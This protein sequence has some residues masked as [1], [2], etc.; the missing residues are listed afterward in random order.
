[1]TTTSIIDRA[2]SLLAGI[3]PGEWEDQGRLAAHPKGTVGT[4]ETRVAIC[5]TFHVLDPKR[6]I[7]FKEMQANAAFIAAS[8]ELV[9]GLVEEVKRLRE[10]VSTISARECAL[11]ERA[12]ELLRKVDSAEARADQLER[13]RDALLEV[14]ERFMP[15]PFALFPDSD[16]RLYKEECANCQPKKEKRKACLLEW[17]AQENNNE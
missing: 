17:A 4:K 2:E 13:E 3:T 7:S 14:A 6:Q 8:P 9:R 15:C 5:N 16:K 11:A 12:S 1:M 10:L